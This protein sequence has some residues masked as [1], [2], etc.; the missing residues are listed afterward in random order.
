MNFFFIKNE[1]NGHLNP[2]A[3]AYT[4]YND[5]LRLGLLVVDVG[6]PA[7]WVRSMCKELR[8]ALRCML[9]FMGFCM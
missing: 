2:V 4:C 7:D 8:I 6:P 5:F 1:E 3:L 9:W